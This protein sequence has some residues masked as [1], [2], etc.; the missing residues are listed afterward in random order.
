MEVHARI[1]A[2]GMRQSGVLAAAGLHALE[3]HVPRLHKDHDH[4]KQLAQG[5]AGIPGITADAAAVETNI[6]MFSVDWGGGGSTDDFLEAVKLRGVLLGA[7]VGALSFF[8]LRCCLLILDLFVECFYVHTILP[9]RAHPPTHSPACLT[10]KTNVSIITR[11]SLL[12]LA[13][14]WRQLCCRSALLST[15]VMESQGATS[16]ALFCT[17]TLTLPTS[18]LLWTL[19]N[20]SWLAQRSLEHT[21]LSV[22]GY[23]R[24]A[25]KRSTCR[26]GLAEDQTS[27]A[28]DN[29]FY[30]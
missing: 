4:A 22:I 2:G 8:D 18:T 23:E 14:G 9:L 11:S 17:S 21:V 5:L 26:E 27:R 19:S 24:C 20:E 12:S 3:H 13:T 6:M 25:D 30:I 29:Y 1:D 28:F 16:C 10:Y 15:P 7:C